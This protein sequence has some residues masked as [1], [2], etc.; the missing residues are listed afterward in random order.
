MVPPLS[1]QLSKLSV[2][3]KKAEDA[4]SAAEKE[5]RDKVIARREQACVAATAAVEKVESDIKSI[6]ETASSN[7]NAVRAKMDS[8]L[9]KLKVKVAQRVHEH[10]VKRAEGRADRLEQE[11]GFAVDYAVASIEQANVA[12]LDAII[13]RFEA[14]EARSS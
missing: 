1:E 11:A 8:D 2:R 5:T 7:W 13:G 12:I 10:D 4:I 3:A 14:E 9:A 6:G